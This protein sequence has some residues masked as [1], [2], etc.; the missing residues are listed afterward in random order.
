MI[1]KKTQYAIKALSY[2]AIESETK[3]KFKIQEISDFCKIPHKFL[4]QILNDLK[5]AEILISKR[6]KNGGYELAK[7]SKDIHMYEVIKAI[8]GDFI[9]L[10]CLKTDAM[11][12]CEGCDNLKSCSVRRLSKKIN[13]FM[14]DNLSELNLKNLNKL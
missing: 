9:D 11:V 8:E 4:E 1:S 12:A 2:M 14:Y 13:I 10:D 5:Q 7:K 3:E 6:G